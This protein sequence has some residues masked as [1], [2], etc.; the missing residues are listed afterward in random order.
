M[1]LTLCSASGLVTMLLYDGLIYIVALTAVNIMNIIFY[2]SPN[3]GMQSAGCSLGKA[4]TWIMT[5]RIILHVRETSRAKH[6]SAVI[7]QPPSW[8]V[9][10]PG[11]LHVSEERRRDSELSFDPYKTISV[12]TASDGGIKVSIQES[13]FV[14]TKLSDEGSIERGIYP[15][16]RSNWD[17]GHAI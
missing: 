2:R 13:V 7:A 5:Q 1:A 4:L 12:N 6:T 16:P 11:V 3:R 10:S 9:V 8:P 14:D 17:K 15:P